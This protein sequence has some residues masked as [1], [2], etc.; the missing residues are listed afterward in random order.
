MN[1]NDEQVPV[2]WLRPLQVVKNYGI[3][4][5]KVRRMIADDVVESVRIGRSVLVSAASVERLFNT[6]S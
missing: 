1:L 3:S 6:A 2:V 5:S 4:E